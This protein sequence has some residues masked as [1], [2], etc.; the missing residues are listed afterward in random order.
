[1]A[2]LRAG[3]T[4]YNEL[5]AKQDALVKERVDHVKWFADNHPAAFFTKFKLSGQNPDLTYPKL[6][7][8]EPDQVAQVYQY[9]KDFFNNVDFGS[10]ST[11]RTPV[12]ANKL[13]KYIRELTPQNADSLIKYSDELIARTKA[14]RELFK[15]TVN[16]IALEYKTPKTMGTEA[17]YVHLI[18]KYWTTETAFWS[19]AEEIKGL[20]G[21]I[22]LM[23]PSLIGKTAQDVVATNEKGEPVSIYGMKSPVKVVFIYSYDCEHCQ[24]EAPEMVQVYNQWKNRGLDVF[25]LCTDKDKGK[26]L[27]FVRKNGMTFQNAIDP[28]R[29]SRYDHK[30]HID[31][32]PELYV[33]DKNNRI[34]ASN[35]SPAQLPEFLESERAKNPW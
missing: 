11:L 31:I 9:R 5:K 10:E 15:F 3:T 34:I 25:A 6:P 21:E 19:N 17:L 29:K 23:K 12:F 33:L 2:K 28:E 1:M 32:T 30:Y 7:N 26:W 16:W 24:K 14:N 8:G 18:D 20:R 4:A 13:R 35:L 22:G 27:E